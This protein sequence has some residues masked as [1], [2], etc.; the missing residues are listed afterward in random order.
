MLA[1]VS[2]GGAA[3]EP[4]DVTYN[5]WVFGAEERGSFLGSQRSIREYFGCQ[6][7][8]QFREIKASSFWVV[9]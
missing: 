8:H 2:E 5:H 1:D 9:D 4:V 3:V 6:R 7:V